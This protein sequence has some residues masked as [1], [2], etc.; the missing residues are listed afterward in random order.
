MTTYTNLSGITAAAITATVEGVLADAFA[1]AAGV[2]KASVRVGA[3]SDIPSGES[4]AGTRR[5]LRQTPAG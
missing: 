1:A 5:R 2:P 3:V 4:S